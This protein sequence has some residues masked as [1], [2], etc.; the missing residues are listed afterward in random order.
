[1]L[2][3]NFGV[4]YL[5]ILPKEP[6]NDELH[7]RGEIDREASGQYREESGREWT[8]GKDEVERA[9]FSLYTYDL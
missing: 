3:V 4:N 7:R 2:F 1:M 5:K 9:A 8:R 6:K